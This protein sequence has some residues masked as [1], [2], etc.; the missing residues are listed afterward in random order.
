MENNTL[1]DHTACLASDMQICR[2]TAKEE[3]G[4]T[5]LKQ[6][7]WLETKTQHGGSTKQQEDGPSSRMQ[8]QRRYVANPLV[9]KTP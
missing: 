8:K 6:E 5:S 7:N 9:I 4:T 2:D 1:D 3:Q